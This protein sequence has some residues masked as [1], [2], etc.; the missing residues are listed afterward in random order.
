MKFSEQWLR[1]WVDPQIGSEELVEQLTMLGLEVDGVA[2]AELHAQIVVAAVVAV[3]PHPDADKLRVCSVDDSSGETLQIVCGAPNVAAGMRV[4]LAR[5]GAELPGGMKI[6]RAKLRGLASAG[7]LCSAAELG[8]S[9][10]AGGLMALPADAPLGKSLSA[11]LD[12]DDAVIDIDLTANRGD[13]FSIR[14]IAK[15]VAARNQLDV[16]EPETPVVAAEIDD[17]LPIELDPAAGCARYCGRVIR[18][19]DACAATPLWMVERLRRCGLRSISAVVDV[20]N[21]VMLELGQPMH[22]FDLAALD[23]GIRV[24]LAEPGERLEILD[25]R[26]LTLD[27]DVTV[28]ADDSRAVA[29]GG[30]M[31]GLHSGVTDATVDVFLES[32]VF[33]PTAIMGRPRRYNAHTDSAHRYERGVD[34]ELQRRAIERATALLLEIAGGRPGPVVEAVLE[35]EL[36]RAGEIRLRR[37]RLDRLL[38]VALPDDEV[39]GVLRRLGVALRG[40]GEGWIARPPSYRYDLR[41]EEDLIEEL[42]RVHGY[43]RIRRSHPS[44]PPQIRPLDEDRVDADQLRRTLV[45]RDYLEAITYSFVDPQLQQL[46]DPQVEALPLANPI[47]ADLSLMRTSLWPGLLRA[48]QRNLNRQQRRVRLFECGL[49][50]LPRDGELLQEPMLA[51]LASGPRMAEQW[52][53]ADEEVD[54]H[55]LRADLDA[56]LELAAASD[57]ALVAER[58]PALHP[59]QSASL[60]A[61]GETVGWIGRLHPRLQSALDLDQSAVLFEIRASILSQAKLPIFKEISR[62]PSIR[63]DIAIVADRDMPMQTLLACVEEAAPDYLTAVVPFDVYTGERVETGCKSVA[64]GLILQ[65]LYRTLTES[66]V[67]EAVSRIVV[68]LQTQLG[69]TLRE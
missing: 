62:F 57:V 50:Y 5:V 28:I 1:E 17:V 3:E 53:A 34:P 13:C 48:L 54:F 29:V 20:T 49:R 69:V 47:S 12:L 33:L 67:E 46:V 45:E 41:I 7:M 32:A 37:A 4:P 36:P 63:R 58:H 26:E 59:G 61:G 38:G 15:E 22:A 43:D 55:D 35:D 24:R 65:E 68:S 19:I 52:G 6:K 42:V 31:G 21:Y 25:G 56:L 14:G 39:E 30:I 11:Y 51:G 16:A 60:R 10:D 40:D 27:D 9:E 44:H 23:G 2:R 8:L 66:E 64:L 18:G